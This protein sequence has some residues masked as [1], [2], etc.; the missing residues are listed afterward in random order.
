MRQETLLF[1]T[2]IFRQ[3]RSLL[4]FLDANAL[5][6]RTKDNNIVTLDISV[7]YRIVPRRPGD[8]ACFCADPALAELAS[9]QRGGELPVLRS[10]EGATLA[11]ARQAGCYPLMPYSNRLGQRR[12]R[13]LGKDYT[14][15]S[16]IDG[17]VKF[18]P[19]AKGRRKKVSVYAS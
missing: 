14:I 2:E 1:T 15:Y 13:W 4:D 10:T 11:Q 19:Y 16:L 12:F 3:D 18:E 7:P 17:Q 8:L 9:T 5:E 6:I